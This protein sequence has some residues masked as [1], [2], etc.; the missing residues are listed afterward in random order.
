IK[1]KLITILQRNYLRLIKMFSRIIEEVFPFLYFY[2][3]ANKKQLVCM[4]SPFQTLSFT[5]GYRMKNSRE[6]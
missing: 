4:I 2:Y 3:I 5:Q 6:T 1:E